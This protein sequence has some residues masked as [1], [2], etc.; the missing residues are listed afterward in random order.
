MVHS[1]SRS[2]MYWRI[3]SRMSKLMVR[4]SAHRVLHQLGHLWR[5]GERDCLGVAVD[6]PIGPILSYTISCAIWPF[7]V[8]QSLSSVS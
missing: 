3:T 7:A 4:P 1:H 6:G 2:S 8:R 5:Q